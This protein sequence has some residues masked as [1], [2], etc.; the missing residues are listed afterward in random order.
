MTF[1]NYFRDKISVTISGFCGSDQTLYAL[2]TCNLQTWWSTK[3]SNQYFP[4]SICWTIFF[5]TPNPPKNPVGK[6]RLF[7]H[8]GTHPAGQAIAHVSAKVHT[9][10]HRRHLK[11]NARI[12]NQWLVVWDLLSFTAALPPILLADPIRYSTLHTRRVNQPNPD[13]VLYTSGRRIKQIGT[14]NLHEMRKP[15]YF[16]VIF[17]NFGNTLNAV[18]TSWHWHLQGVRGRNL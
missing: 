10:V 13:F 9:E 2:C 17:N 3:R 12:F 16:Q 6:F 5:S 11:T 15:K 1:E 7:N 4:F 14:I 18:A 8:V